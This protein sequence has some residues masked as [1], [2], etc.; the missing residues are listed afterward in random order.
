MRELMPSF[1]STC[2]IGAIGEP[3]TSRQGYLDASFPVTDTSREAGQQA[4]G[5]IFGRTADR[6]EPRFARAASWSSSRSCPGAPASNSATR[7][8]RGNGRA[9]RQLEAED[10][11]DREKLVGIGNRVEVA[12]QAVADIDR[13]EGDRTT[14]AD[15]HQLPSATTGHREQH[16]P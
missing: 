5:R 10:R 4:M 1:P 2:R 11:C 14:V 16:R 13:D 15:R 7:V 3:E 12:D 8:P 6:D 9:N